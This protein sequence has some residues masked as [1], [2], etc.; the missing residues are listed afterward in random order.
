MPSAQFDANL[1]PTPTPPLAHQQHTTH[2]TDTPNTNSTTTDTPTPSSSSTFKPTQQQRINA[3][4]L[5]WHSEAIAEVAQQLHRQFKTP[6]YTSARMTMVMVFVIGCITTTT[7]TVCP[8]R[9]SRHR[10]RDGGR[11][12][13]WGDA[14]EVLVVCI[15]AFFANGKPLTINTQ[16]SN[17]AWG[18]IG[19]GSG[20]RR[21]LMQQS[22]GIVVKKQ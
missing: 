13:I 7:M 15:L 16:Q 14:V 22:T 19:W 10:V 18:V 5:L 3:T 11:R 17:V 4:M 6:S 21:N 2:T 9:C 20:K 1:S 8:R 12:G